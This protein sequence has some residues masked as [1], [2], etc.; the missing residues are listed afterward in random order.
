MKIILEITL[1]IALTSALNLFLY[2][3]I[4]R[5]LLVALATSRQQLATYVRQGKKPVIHERDRLFWVLLSKFSS[6]WQDL[7]V[8]VKPATVI[9]WDRRRFRRYGKKLSTPKNK[10]GHPPIPQE[11]IEF[12]RD[13]SRQHPEYGATR[14]AGI[15]LENFGISHSKN[16]VEKYRIKSGKP[17]RDSQSW[18][19]FLKNHGDVIWCCDFIVQ[20]TF[21]FVPIYVFIILELGCRK[22]V[23]CSVSR[24]S[25][26]ERPKTRHA[27]N[28]LS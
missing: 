28:P 24:H 6:G 15:L 8:I 10:V 17:P 26:R 1:I 12:I 23:Q 13:I 20:Y 14:I 4:H 5:R 9:S 22:I 3:Y 18:R 19:T 11:H 21:F 25:G 16:T 2:G 27:G 7:L